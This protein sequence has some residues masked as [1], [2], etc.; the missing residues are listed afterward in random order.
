MV[1]PPDSF[2]HEITNRLEQIN[3]AVRSFDFICSD[4]IYA[5]DAHPML[6]FKMKKY[7]RDWNDY[8]KRFKVNKCQAVKLNEED[9]GEERTKF[10]DFLLDR[11]LDYSESLQIAE[12]QIE[13]LLEENPFMPEDQSFHMTPEDFRRHGHQVIDWIADYYKN[14]ESF[15]VLSRVERA[16]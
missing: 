6:K 2:L 5:L 4:L 12:D 15:A 1:L 8:K 7:Y 13:A 3:K 10:E 11:V 16:L 9:I 14:I